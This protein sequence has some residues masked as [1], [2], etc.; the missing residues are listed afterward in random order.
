MLLGFRS[1]VPRFPAITYGFDGLAKL[2]CGNRWESSCATNTRFDGYE[3]H[4]YNFAIRVF[5]Q[6]YK[7]NGCLQ[8]YVSLIG[9]SEYQV[10]VDREQRRLQLIE[11]T[12]F[13]EDSGQ[14]MV[15]SLVAKAEL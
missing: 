10:V 14:M 3:T 15:N 4:S 9:E 5:L 11:N 6:A 12:E 13:V 1:V 2:E 8:G 7:R